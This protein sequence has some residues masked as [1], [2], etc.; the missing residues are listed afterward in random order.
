MACC[1]T[2][3]RRAGRLRTS[4]FSE[5]CT[6]RLAST[7]TTTRTRRP[8]PR[9]RPRYRTDPE[10]GAFSSG[11]GRRHAAPLRPMKPLRFVAT[12]AL[13]AMAC[14][15]PK[16]GTMKGT[17]FPGHGAISLQIVPN[18]VVATKISGKT[19]EFPFDVIVRETA[20]RAVT[21]SRVSADVFAVGGIHVANESYDAARIASLGYS[22]NVPGNGELRYHFSPRKDVTDDRLF[23]GVYAQIR[24]DA[25]DET[26]TPTSATTTVTVT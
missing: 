25:Y 3:S 20:G 8:A 9:R 18:P 7:P 12:L 26:N 19:Y 17:S 4:G 23:G 10:H 14:V 13:C 1:D 16:T 22:T 24:V 15:T 21:I 6:W 5:T 11:H 2:T